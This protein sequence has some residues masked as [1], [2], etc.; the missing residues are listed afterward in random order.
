MR[1]LPAGA[2][3]GVAVAVL[4]LGACAGP[5][6]EKTPAARRGVEGPLSPD[7]ALREFR[8]DEGLRVELVAAEPDVRS[9]VAM[10]FDEAGKLWV[11]D[12]PDYPTGP[13][14]GGP[15]QG[16][17]VTLE[18]RDADGR[19]EHARV[20][21]SE[22]LF[23]TGILPWK[24]GVFVTGQFG[25][26]YLKDEDGDG[27]ADR[28]EELYD[29][30]Y[31]E[32]SQHF[33]NA[34]TLGLDGWVYVA[35]GLRTD[36]VTPV[37]A[38]EQAVDVR[39]R[40]F[41]FD[42][43]GGR[44]EAAAGMGQ[45]GM[46]FDR[47]GRRFTVTN[48]NHVIHA[49]VPLGY[50]E[51]SPYLSVPVTRDDQSPGGAAAIHPLSSNWT[52]S[53]R[54]AGTFT[55]ACGIAV[56]EGNLLGERYRGAAFTAEPT[57]NL[58]HQATL[59]PRGGSFEVGRARERVEFLAS[60]DPW[61][62]PVFVTGGPDGA[63]YVVDMYRA[64]IE[65]PV[66]V[67][68]DRRDRMDTR[69]GSGLGRI[70][71]IVPEAGAPRPDLADLGAAP[72][73]RLAEALESPNRWRRATAHRL[74]LERRDTRAVPSLERL[75]RASPSPEARI[76]AGWL[77]ASLSALEPSDVEALLGHDHPRVREHGVRL[78][79]PW[80]ADPALGE[81]L[82]ER[83]EDEDARVRFQ[84]AL[85]LGGLDE[86]RILR[87]LARI[88]RRAPAD[89]WTRLAVA[90][91]AHGREVGLLAELFPEGS[92]I[93]DE[94]EPLQP[95]LRELADVIGAGGEPG[96][97]RRAAAL[98][99]SWRGDP[100]WSLAGLSGMLDGLRR[101]SASGA[102]ALE[103]LNGVV[104]G[105]GSDALLARLPALASDRERPLEVRLDAVRLT[106]IAGWAESRETLASLLA[107]AEDFALAVEAARAIAA[108]R[109]SAAGRLLLEGWGR[110]P[111]EVRSAV[112]AALQSRS[113]GPEVL[114]EALEAGRVRAGELTPA[115]I[116]QL[117]EDPAL[118]ARARL[119]LGRA[120]VR[121][122]E[123]VA[124]YRDALREGGRVDRGREVFRENCATC[125]RVDGL[126]VEVGPD[127]SDTRTKS[128]EALL[129]D[130]LDPTRAIDAGYVSYSVVTEEGERLSGF[131]SARGGAGIRLRGSDGR[132]RT[133]PRELAGE[134][135][136]DGVSV[137]PEGFEDTISVEEMRDLIEFLKNWRFGEG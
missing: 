79:E 117:R 30:S 14:T 129:V 137:M 13:E 103:R 15:P 86:D 99:L 42:P 37:G 22:L 78:G 47:W 109:E 48:R 18:D 29:G 6:G 39:G 107:G 89:R 7:Q 93:G 55:A 25:I 115:A 69:G 8:V 66:Y 45:F 105:S 100:R 70:W 75:V 113:D 131:I 118:G 3:S 112:L 108:Y 120:E 136:A 33:L 71:R 119:V 111:P 52:T 31:T 106:G 43:A 59:T 80:L 64:D 125:H 40:D 102:A 21:R 26:D 134:L 28:H 83:V 67:P 58:V 53:I 60:P 4:A 96:A 81:R 116:R 1:G 95:L 135:R 127:I 24:G 44:Q 23:A 85:S 123:V 132:E 114:L 133:V 63:L 38:P 101:G 128:R 32:I 57:G 122:S 76:H 98:S 121:R 20:F 88:A 82:V 51:R 35:N 110:Y 90:S 17:I 94:A 50:L 19:Y 92:E 10:A 11:V 27:R 65:H 56:Y 68:E 9:P 126:G 104:A 49:V 62:R 72:P 84:L 73:E 34:P 124:R 12:M 97:L 46:S 74:L 5:A 36:T 77:L 130:V 91:A 16:R 54:H 87:P 2:V 61:F 41:R